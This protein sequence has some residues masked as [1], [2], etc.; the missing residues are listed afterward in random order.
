MG[1]F[2][3]TQSWQVGALAMGSLLLTSAPSPAQMAV[4]QLIEDTAPDRALGTTVIPFNQQIDQI[5]G[6]TTRGPNLFHS[7]QEFN[8]GTNRGVYFANPAGI[9]NILTRITG[10]NPSNIEGTLGVFGAANLF[11]LNP[12]GILFGPNASLDLRGGSFHA[13][14]AS[15]IQFGTLGEFS[16]TNPQPPAPLLTINPS[17]YF[18]T[19]KE[20]Q[21][22][23]I[24]RSRATQTVLGDD[25]VGLQ[26]PNGQTLLLLG[27]NVTL[28][29]GLVNALG[30][31][32]EIGAVAGTGSIGVNA[33]G[34][35]SI[36]NEVQQADVLFTNQAWADVTLGG[37][38]D[39]GSV[40]YAGILPGLGF[41]TSQAGDITLDATG[42]V[43]ISQSGTV[44]SV[45]SNGLGN[46][47]N[48]RISA[49]SITVDGNA[50]IVN[51]ISGQGNAGDIIIN[52]TGALTIFRSQ[53]RNW[54]D[55]GATGNGGNIFIDTE[56]LSFTGGGYISAST[57]GVGNGGNVLVR[58]TNDIR[59]EQ[60][61]ILSIV[62]SQA[63][64]N[65]GNIDVSA[66]ALSMT[67]GSM[68]DARTY[69]RG[70]AGNVLLNIQ[71]SV[72]LDGVVLFHKG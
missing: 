1:L 25:T 67:R 13:S 70:N 41:P 33:N 48:I 69:G 11:F 12:N 45:Y 71:D 27:G 24:N 39:S 17:A 54:L 58:A 9:Q 52:T 8:V 15:S 4:A 16:A 21:G 55:L 29:G 61:T 3:Q 31:R 60:S 34:S 19:A 46:T 42:S 26:V 36:P 35:L 23:I 65:A 5:T 40:L 43:K 66:R 47:G 20:R 59:L 7:F 44:N 50:L 49:G 22:E 10:N 62:E 72:V 38:G 2:T 14:T 37:A 56:S 30:G 53:I 32:V 51:L 64:G 28:D 63:E 6:G 18:F 68:L 57:F